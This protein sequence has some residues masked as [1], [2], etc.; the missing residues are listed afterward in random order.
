MRWQD[1]FDD[2][3]GQAAAQDAAEVRGEVADRTRRE[4]GSLQLTDRLRPGTEHPL[5]VHLAG[6]GTVRG[7][8]SEVGPD[9]LLLTESAGCEALVPLSAVLSVTGVGQRAEVAEG[10]VVRRLDLRWVLRGLARSRA[11]V[12]VVLRDG[13]VATGTLDQVGAEHV[14]LAEHAPGEARRAGAVRQVRVIPLSALS[15]VRSS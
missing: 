4:R 14:D 1:L 12:T 13:S 3:E 15:L 2:L 8:L 9:W 10:E 11:G 5:A 6:A 7:T